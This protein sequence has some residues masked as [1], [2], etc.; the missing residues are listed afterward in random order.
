MIIRRSVRPASPH[1]GPRHRSGSDLR[2]SKAA[3]TLLVWSALGPLA[4]TAFAAQLALPE[5]PYS[6]TVIDQDLTA[7]LHEFGSN[8]N[9]KVNV[10]PEVRGRIQ[11]RL[12]ELPPRAFLDRLAALYNFEW[13]FDGLVVHIT[14][15]REAQTR[16]LVVS[17]LSFDR[18][19]YA[20]DALGVSDT[21]YVIRPAPGSGLALVAGPPRFVTLVEQTLA[22]LIAEDQARPRTLRSPDAPRPPMPL[23]QESVL[24][25]F[26][27]SD[28][29]IIRDGRPEHIAGLDDRRRTART[30]DQ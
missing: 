26:R 29:T 28:T 6:Y 1:P 4:Q 21:R 15:V 18:L 10:S 5:T 3:I 25:V 2:R 30:T 11:G 24:T 17:P 16:L 8:L 12:P 23:L 20:L 9:I 7:A 22:G 27:G 14:S 13:Y 19:R